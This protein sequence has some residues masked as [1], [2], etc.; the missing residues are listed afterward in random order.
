MDADELMNLLHGSDPVKVELNRL[1]NELRDKE[2]ELGEALVENKALSFINL[3]LGLGDLNLECELAKVDGK[4]KLAES[5]LDSKN[6]EIKKINEEKKSSM[7]AP[8]CKWGHIMEDSYYQ[9]SFSRRVELD[10]TVEVEKLTQTDERKTLDRELARAKVTANRVATVVAN[11]WKDSNDKVMPVKQ[12]LEERR[13]LQS[14]LSK[15]EQRCYNEQMSCFLSQECSYVWV[16]LLSSGIEKFQLRLRVLEETLRSSS[17]GGRSTPDGRSS[18]LKHAKGTSKSFDGGS[19]SADRAKVLLNGPGGKF[20]S[21]Q[22]FDGTKDETKDSTWKDKQEDKT[23]DLP[24]EVITLRK[25]GHEKDQ[26]LKDKDDA[27]E[28]PFPHKDAT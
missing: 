20:N 16:K 22:S 3:S 15:P 5:V 17:I 14:N 1:E 13:F 26:C 27:I 10:K 25:A 28:L 23:N 19:R 9:L 24:K 6:L 8:A 21:S 2:R 18:I 4:L 12:W 11:E 7:A